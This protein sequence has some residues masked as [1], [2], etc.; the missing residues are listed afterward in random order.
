MFYD[1]SDALVWDADWLRAASDAAGVA[2]WSW[3]VDTNAL[4]MDK[5]AYALGGGAPGRP[6]GVLD[7]KVRGR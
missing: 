2:L 3:N 1:T 5:R 7:G 6:A 4:H